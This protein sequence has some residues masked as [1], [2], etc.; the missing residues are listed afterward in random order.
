MPA[1]IVNWC[2]DEAVSVQEWSAYAGVLAGVTPTFSSRSRTGGLP[3]ADH[4]QR[5][6]LAITGRCTVGWR[7]GFRLVYDAL[8]G[9]EP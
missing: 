9:S 5:E 6:R 7:E 1:N 8:Y 3:R 2:G 4:E